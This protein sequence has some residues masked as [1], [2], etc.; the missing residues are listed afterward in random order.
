[1]SDRRGQTVKLFLVD[2]SAGG[3]VTAEIGNWTGHAVIA[4]RGRLVDVL[5]RDEAAR[6]GVYFLLGEVGD[7]SERRPVYIGESDNVGERI[8][9]HA[10]DD[11]K[12]FFERFC[13]FTSKDQNLTKAHVRYLESRLTEVAREADRAQL[14]NGT[15]PNGG[16][17]PE[18]DRSDMEYYL[19]QLR[20][21][22][23]VLGYDFLRSA[24][25]RKVADAA[26]VAQ[27][28]T[29]RLTLTDRKAGVIATAIES[30]GDFVV[31]EGSTARS[32]ATASFSTH[33]K[34]TAALR[35]R[36]I[37]DG[38]LAPTDQP[39]L[40]RFTR[41]FAF[42]SPSAASSVILARSDN[43]LL[44]WKIEATGDSLFDYRAKQTEEVSP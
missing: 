13:F 42:N 6:T 43:G 7:L 27:S 38:T 15:A 4:P 16:V 3:I 25:K 22:M 29:V 32:S 36:L 37:A 33:A 20:I 2:G 35:E 28:E 8:K 21:I 23:P 14:V 44:S 12:D 5:R 1:M 40:M 41:D 19:D 17:L 24:P 26:P 31:A 18:S 30:D 9:Q 34:T 11:K 39:A 10:R